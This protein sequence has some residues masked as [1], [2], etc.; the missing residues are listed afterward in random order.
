LLS[1]KFE[2]K[3]SAK[4]VESTT[5]PSEEVWIIRKLFSKFLFDCML[6]QLIIFLF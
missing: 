4:A 5:S 1:G 2:C 6:D 3:V